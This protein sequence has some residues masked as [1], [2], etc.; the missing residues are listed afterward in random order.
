MFA[1]YTP[2]GRSF[3]GTLEGL[4]TIEKSNRTTVLRKHQAIDDPQ[5]PNTTKYSVSTNAVEAY[6]KVIKKQDEIYPIFHAYQV[7]SLPVEV[8]RGDD[9]FKVAIEKF[10]K[11]PFQEFPIINN[12]NELIGSLSRQQTYEFI[13]KNQVTENKINANKTLAELF[14]NDSSK[15]YSAEPV[16]DIR[17]IAA[18]FIENELHTI[19]IIEN[20]GKIVGIISRADIIKAAI[21]DPALSLWC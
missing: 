16:T 2:N 21:K 13:L 3:L 1:V 7:M 8:L 6:R 12:K 9:L 14:L 15:A 19:P 18:L 17:R 11:L 10:T 4:R 5:S 20:T